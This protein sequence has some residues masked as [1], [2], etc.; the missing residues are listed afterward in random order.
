M[1]RRNLSDRRFVVLPGCPVIR[2][3]F[4][5]PLWPKFLFKLRWWS[6]RLARYGFI[7]FLPDDGSGSAGNSG[8]VFEVR[9]LLV[10]FV[11]GLLAPIGTF[12][13][14]EVSFSFVV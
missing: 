5:C 4:M 8:Y 13:F 6:V 11:L 14:E 3:S 9:R 2:C 10:G 7:R 1:L 12:L